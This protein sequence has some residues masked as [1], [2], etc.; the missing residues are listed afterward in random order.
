MFIPPYSPDL[1]PIEQAFAKLKA[2][3]RAAPCER[4]MLSGKHSAA[5]STASPQKNAPTSS[6]TTVISSQREK[7]LDARAV[8]CRMRGGAEAGS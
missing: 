4:S 2:L 7:G 1:N 6:A 5:S 3:S 8:Y